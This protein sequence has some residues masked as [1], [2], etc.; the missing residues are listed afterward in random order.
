[1]YHINPACTKRLLASMPKT[2]FLQE[3][4]K[5][6]DRLQNSQPNTN[7]HFKYKRLYDWCIQHYNN[8]TI[9]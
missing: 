7:E 9:K 6:R 2:E 5:I 1:M 3:F 4:E 8:K